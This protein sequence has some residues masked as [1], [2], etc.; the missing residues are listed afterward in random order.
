M[1]KVAP[2]IKSRTPSL[3]PKMY[4]EDQDN[5]CTDIIKKY[6]IETSIHGLKYIFEGKRNYVER[7]FWIIACL[8]M[9]TCGFYLIYQVCIHFIWKLRST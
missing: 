4:D 6:F 1:T 9:A 3:L 5:K 2:T 7:L 8:T